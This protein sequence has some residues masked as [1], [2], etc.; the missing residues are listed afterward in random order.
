ML[1]MNDIQNTTQVSTAAKPRE[2]VKEGVGS[3]PKSV[4]STHWS[5][6]PQPVSEQD[7]EKLYKELEI[8]ALERNFQLKFSVDEATGRTVI[9][10]INSETHK[11]V[12]EI[13][14]EEI[15]RVAAALEQ[16]AQQIIDTEV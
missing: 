1:T 7:W 6:P 10:I 9:K 16:L 8:Y 15:L 2:K 14:P 5:A 3:P 13:P 11:I 12:R 4:E